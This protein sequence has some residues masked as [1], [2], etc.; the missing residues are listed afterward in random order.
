MSGPT[1]PGLHQGAVLGHRDVCPNY[2]DVLSWWLDYV[3]SSYIATSRTSSEH[4]SV[5]EQLEHALAKEA[6]KVC[7]M[8]WNLH[9]G[10]GTPRHAHF[11]FTGA[12]T[13]SSWSLGIASILLVK[14]QGTFK[15]LILENQRRSIL[16][17]FGNKNRVKISYI[18]L[19][20]HSLLFECEISCH[21]KNKQIHD[22]AIAHN[23]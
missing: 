1:S 17:S 8:N 13:A 2:N 23:N 4:Y 9:T 6:I 10:R 3:I 5:S 15:N 20:V 22:N 12:W 18:G 7:V 16:A 21:P 19:R 14:Q 11:S